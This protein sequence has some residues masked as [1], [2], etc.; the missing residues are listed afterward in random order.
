M[1]V[2]RA[3]VLFSG[4]C[5]FWKG[6]MLTNTELYSPVCVMGDYRCTLSPQFKESCVYSCSLLIHARV[7]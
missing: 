5:R 6:V 4:Y 3:L 2:R 1:W 7:T